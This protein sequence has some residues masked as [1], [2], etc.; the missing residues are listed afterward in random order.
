M[1]A[2]QEIKMDERESAL[3]LFRRKRI[4]LQEKQTAK[5][6][7]KYNKRV[8]KTKNPIEKAR[9][10]G[11]EAFNTHLSP[12]LIEED[13]NDEN[14]MHITTCQYNCG[15]ITCRVSKDDITKKYI[16]GAFNHVLSE[17][18][19]ELHSKHSKDQKIN[20]MKEYSLRL[21]QP[22]IREE[23]DKFEKL[24]QRFRMDKIK[25][26]KRRDADRTM[27]DSVTEHESGF[28]IYECNRPACEKCGCT[29]ASKRGVKHHQK[30]TQ[31]CGVIAD[32]M[33]N[34]IPAPVVEAPVEA[35]APVSAPV[36]E[37]PV[38]GDEV[39]Y[40]KAKKKKLNVVKKIE[41]EKNI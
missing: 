20:T 31:K 32:R 25:Q 29:F 2:T 6:E 35:P 22:L 3:D 27:I 12:I 13:E 39:F 15:D 40:I 37:A 26:R 30:T 38:I 10:L 23:N 24:A 1:D 34:G 28:T 19:R 4:E 36:V 17:L 5:E 7:E 11:M 21:E 33:A 14:Q 9:L 41:I 8:E 16:K 18:L